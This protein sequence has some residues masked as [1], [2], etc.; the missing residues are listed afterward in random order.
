MQYSG[1]AIIAASTPLSAVAGQV[2]QLPRR[3]IPGTD[4]SLAVVGYGNSSAFRQGD[5]ELSRELIGLFLDYGG[6]YVDTSGSSRDTVGSIMREQGAHE[7]M[8]L[9][10]YIEGENLQAMRDE[11]ARVL[12][13]QGGDSLDLVLSRA[14]I[15]FGERRDQ[16]Q[17]LKDDQLTRY[18]GVARS[19]KRFYSSIME[20]M[21]DGALDFIQ[22]NYS[23]MEPEAAEEILP[24]AQEKGVAV[25]INRPFING[26]Y[27]GMVREQALPEWAADFDCDSWAQFSL[28][29]ILANP[30][31]TCVLTETSNPR[32][33]IDNFGAGFGRL[34]DAEERKRMEAVIRALM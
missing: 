3:A 26:E 20:L 10:T 16:F 14:P 25:I 1:A 32:H 31:V 17:R 6:S 27:F 15:D 30:A 34:P 19:N 13:V 22:V 28:K 18:T 11:I 7:Q 9:G 4:E 2:R 21:N 8:F 29:Y 12:D 5:V 24:L 33:A 23:I